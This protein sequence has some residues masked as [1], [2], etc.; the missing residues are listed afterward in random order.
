[1][2]CRCFVKNELKQILILGMQRSFMNWQP[3]KTT[4]SADICA[5]SEKKSSDGITALKY[6]TMQRGEIWIGHY[7]ADI[8]FC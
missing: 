2:S 1:M 6:R 5:G 7:V 4:G 3:S 8:V